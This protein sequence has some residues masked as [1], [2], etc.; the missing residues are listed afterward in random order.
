MADELHHNLSF[1]NFISQIRRWDYCGIKNNAVT[2]LLV[3]IED[4]IGK[5]ENLLYLLNIR[6]FSAIAKNKRAAKFF[7]YP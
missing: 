1:I 5:P 3:P 7:N 4:M 2:Q 6:I